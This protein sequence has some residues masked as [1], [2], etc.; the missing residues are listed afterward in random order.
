[1]FTVL[2]QVRERFAVERRAALAFRA[3]LAAQRRRLEF[4]NDFCG[5]VYELQS[6][7]A[8]VQG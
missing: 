2:G 5:V 6:T 4:P 8:A 7:I 1:M 3:P